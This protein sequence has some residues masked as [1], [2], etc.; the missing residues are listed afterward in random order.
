MSNWSSN[1]VD[2]T[3]ISNAHRPQSSKNLQIKS[4]LAQ[5]EQSKIAKDD[6]QIFF[7]K[8]VKRI[9][10]NQAFNLKIIEVRQNRIQ[11]CSFLKNSISAASKLD[12]GLKRK[13]VAKFFFI[14]DLEFK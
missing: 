2:N 10:R 12:E 6:G 8:D 3:I 14:L 7:L 4:I 1:T 13:I 11:S 9:K 5:F